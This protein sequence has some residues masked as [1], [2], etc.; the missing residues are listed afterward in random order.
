MST[1]CRPWLNLTLVTLLCA[2]LAHTPR[3][4]ADSGDHQHKMRQ[5]ALY[6]E[7]KLYNQALRELKD[8]EQTPEGAQDVQ[9]SRSM[10][11]AYYHTYNIN[12]ALFYLR[13]A[14]RLTTDGQLKL[15]LAETYQD[16]TKSYGL[17]H[18]Q[19]TTQAR[20]SI[21][22][23]PERTI[24]NPQRRKSLSV[25]Q[26]QLKRGITTPASFYLPYGSYLANAERFQLKSNLPPPTV[27]L[28]L[29][30]LPTDGLSTKGS[31]WVYITLGGVALIA[32]TVGGYYLMKNDSSNRVQTVN[33]QFE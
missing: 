26:A 24:V 28:M 30:P 5:V 23:T 13:Q 1:P 15:Q 11:I 14:R 33:V 22:L 32:T 17:V 8:I 29:K 31:K 27:K 2:S 6:I 7:A 25:A 12:Q 9:V 19:S 16:W 18:F 4:H 3:A 21:E 10:S 20:G